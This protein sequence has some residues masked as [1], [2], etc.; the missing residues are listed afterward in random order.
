M[1]QY[2]RQVAAMK[3]QAA[4]KALSLRMAAAAAVRAALS[5]G[6]R[7]VEE[8][9][10][11]RDPDDERDRLE[12]LEALEEAEARWAKEGRSWS[13]WATAVTLGNP[14][15]AREPSALSRWLRSANVR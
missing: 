15:E 5:S 2:E 6:P 9:Y 1:T 11:F 13:A 7:A 14:G 4:A 3:A 10:D 8:S 12:Y